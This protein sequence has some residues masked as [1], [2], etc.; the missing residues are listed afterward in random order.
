[1]WNTPLSS[2]FQYNC[3]LVFPTNIVKQTTTN[4]SNKPEIWVL[5][6]TTHSHLLQ[7]N[8]DILSPQ[9]NTLSSSNC[10]QWRLSSY[11]L[12]VFDWWSQ[13][14]AKPLFHQLWSLHLL[15]PECYYSQCLNLAF[16]TLQSLVLTMST[17]FSTTPI[18]SSYTLTKSS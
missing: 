14:I 11:L 8:S 9:L 15:L 4:R 18:D 10:L 1:M 16:K 13:R 2:L 6:L 12:L 7:L 17:S 3:P 5:S